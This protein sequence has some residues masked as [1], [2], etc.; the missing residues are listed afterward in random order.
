MPY[1]DIYLD[2]TERMDKAVEHLIE[3]F[4]TV[5]SARATPGLVENIRVDYYGAMTPLKQIA[6][7]GV[8]DPQLIAIKPYDPSSADAINRAIQTSELG[9]TPSLDGKLIR[10]TV[11]PLSEER[12][13]KLV[14]QL[15]KI[16]EEA[17]VAIRNIRRD[18][19]KQADQEK[20]D[21]DMPEDDA[22]KLKDDI[23]EL[24]SEHEKKIDTTLEDKT[25]EIMEV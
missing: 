4:R 14:S 13:K 20:K 11:P 5:R 6:S 16:A 3:Q 8:P 9:L 21:G 18:A 1:D 12:R 24:T 25:T 23:Q 2:A 22:F 15:H 17:K 7:I 19:N 10:L